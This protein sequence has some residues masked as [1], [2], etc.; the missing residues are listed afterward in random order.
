M[1]SVS[2][3]ASA[4][5]SMAIDVDAEKRF[6]GLRPQ[7]ERSQGHTY[8]YVRNFMCVV[9]RSISQAPPRR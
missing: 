3:R 2:V 9:A 7:L 1:V 4:D 6:G 5:G 8:F